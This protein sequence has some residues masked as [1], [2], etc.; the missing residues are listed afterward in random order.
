M[1]PETETGTGGLKRWKLLLAPA[2]AAAVIAGLTW[3]GL[4]GDK[5]P[6][7]A[8]AA[9]GLLARYAGFDH[10]RVL[11][12]SD[13]S[14]ADLKARLATPAGDMIDQEWLSIAYV[15]RSRLTGDFADL[16]K[17]RQA[18][19]AGIAMSPPGTG[20]WLAKASAEYAAHRIADTQAALDVVDRY[21][22]PD[23]M[24]RG[25]ARAM[26]ADI[27]F[28]R[29]DYRGMERLLA[30]TETID[31]WP[32]L[33]FRKAL[34]ARAR[35]DFDA[36]RAAFVQ[37]DKI[38]SD[39]TPRFRADM[40]MRLG[41]LE[42]AQGRWDSAR[43]HYQQSIRALPGYWRAE[44]KLAQMDA[45]AGKTAQALAVFERIADRWNEPDAM[46]VA[47][48]LN[49]DLG[50]EDKAKVWIARADRVWQERLKQ[51]PEAAWGHALEHELAFGDPKRALDLALKNARNRP[52]GIPMLLLAEAWN[53]NGQPDKA[54]A[55]CMA[56]EKSGWASADQWTIRSVALDKLG[57]T[58]Q[59]AAARAKAVAINPREY[60]PNPALAWF[61][62]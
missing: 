56:V 33:W 1:P 37:A 40:Q 32:G 2:G 54:L 60:D 27:A 62:D 61:H 8:E 16:V 10:A 42:F 17:A 19:Q 38:N 47:A 3:F 44:M 34:L 31:N 51:L 18:A 36:A 29:G 4:D 9:V 28:S 13:K 26:R 57:R 22:V 30:E 25:E 20:P 35:G 39:P 6:P 41:E 7:P 46:Y 58:E 50:Q 59:A 5:S 43:N 52:Y 49:R 45:I 21:V 11:A 53:A 23:V 55:V 12:E 48:G 24:T 15:N 14:I